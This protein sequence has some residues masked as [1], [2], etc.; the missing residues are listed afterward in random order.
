MK[1]QRVPFKPVEI[2]LIQT[3]LLTFGSKARYSLL[4]CFDICWCMH[5]FIKT[6]LTQVWLAAE[7]A[8]A[9][10]TAE[11]YETQYNKFPLKRKLSSGLMIWY[12]G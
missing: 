8:K 10:L 2:S 9:M 1:F 5:Q 12:F 4:Q 3:D 11:A 6:L 7:K